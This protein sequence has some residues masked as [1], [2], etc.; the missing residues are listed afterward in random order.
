MAD[1][2]RFQSLSNEDK[3]QFLSSL[4]GGCLMFVHIQQALQNCQRKINLHNNYTWYNLFSPLGILIG[5]RAYTNEG[6]IR[7][8]EVGD[9]GFLYLVQEEVEVI[10]RIVKDKLTYIIIIHGTVFSLLWAF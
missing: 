2:E 4:R 3:K 6:R 1:W 8:Y 10:P 9:A 5:V 7:F